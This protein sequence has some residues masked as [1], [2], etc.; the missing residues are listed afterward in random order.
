[1]SS[2]ITKVRAAVARAAAL[3]K[4]NL[5]EWAQV[6]ATLA[7]AEQ[8]RIQNLVTLAHSVKWFDVSDAAESALTVRDER[9][10]RRLR[11]EIAEQL[12]VTDVAG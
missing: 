5:A 9:F 4:T 1:M 2:L 6:Q 11:P 8:L 3:E 12:G 7:V 10:R